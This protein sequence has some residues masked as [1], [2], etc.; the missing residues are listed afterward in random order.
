[1]INNK[2]FALVLSGGSCLG[3]AHVGVLKCLE[4]NNIIPDLIVGTS[5]GALIGGAYAYGLPINE[6]E[7]KVLSFNKNQIIDIKFVPFMGESILSS[8]KLDKYLFSLFGEKTIADCKIKFIATAVNLTKGELKYFNSGLL[9]QVIRAS[10]AVPGVFAPF[11]IGAY[12]YIDGSVMDNLPTYIAKKNKYD[13]VIAINVIDYNKA[14]MHSKTCMHSLLNALTLSQ[15]EIVNLKT[16]ADLVINLKLK[17][18]PLMSFKAEDS[19]ENIENGYNQ[20]KENLDK[21]KALF[22]I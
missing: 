9:W 13:V 20:T 4:E 14:I 12:K 16:N 1:M 8:K 2:T 15:K 11:K 21:I 10:S 22:E 17:E 18:I 7:D 5:A 3:F 19:K 6:I